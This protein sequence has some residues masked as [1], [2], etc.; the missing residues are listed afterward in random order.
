MSYKRHKFSYRKSASKLHRAVGNALRTHPILR[1]LRSYQEYPIPKTPFHIDWFILDLKMAIECHGEQH[2][3]P[4]AFDG[5]KEK[6]KHAFEVQLK[7]DALK[8]R[9]CVEQGWQIIEIW[10]YDKLDTDSIA[11]KI[12]ASL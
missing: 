12:L 9:L 3:G 11:R 7:R 5:D 1:A 8:R 2:D 10:Y 4:V 6:A